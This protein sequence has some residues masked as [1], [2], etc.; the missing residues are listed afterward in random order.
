MEKLILLV[1]DSLFMRTW[2]KKTISEQIDIQFIEAANGKEAIEMYTKFSPHVVLMDITMPKLSGIESL[3]EIIKIDSQ[4]TIIMCT[5]L[6]S[7]MLV[8][9]AI[10]SGAKDFIVKPHFHNLI[11]I[12]RKFI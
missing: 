2:L 10:Q 1:D 3:K 11:P 4:A 9:E 6:G 8:T 7:K 12:L 5:S